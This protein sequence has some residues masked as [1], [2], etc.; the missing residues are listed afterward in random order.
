MIAYDVGRGGSRRI[1]VIDI[2]TLRT[3]E[4]VGTRQ[5]GACEVWA[6]DGASIYFLTGNRLMRVNASGGTT[7]PLGASPYY[8]G[9]FS[10]GLARN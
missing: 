1:D 5:F 9:P 7:Q 2:N 3:R 6:P 8:G 10:I 4:L